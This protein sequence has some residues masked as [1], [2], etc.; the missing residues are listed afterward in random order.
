V[1]PDDPI[2]RLFALEQFGI[3]LGLDN[4]RCL[5]TALGNPQHRFDTVHVGGTNGKGSVTAMVECAV[6]HAGYRT[7]RY[8][9]PHLAHI[10]ERIAVDGVA[11]QPERFREVTADVLAVV[12]RLRALGTLETTPTF[13][14]VTTAIAFEAFRRAGVEVGVIEVGLGGRFDATNVISPRV[15]AITSI[16]L[17]HQKH[18]GDSLASI[19]FEKAGILK[20]DVPAVIGD[21]Q[22]EAWNVI[23]KVAQEKGVELVTADS[24][25]VQSAVLRDGRA[26]IA[27]VT[28]RARYGEVQLGLSGRHQIANAVVAIRILELL[29]SGDWQVNA[30]DIVAGL[31][32]VTWPARLEWLRLAQGGQLLLDAAHNVAGAQALAEYLSDSGVAPL[33]MVLAVMKDKDVAGIVSALAA[34]ASRFVVTSV[35]KPRALSARALAESVRR[36]APAT[37][38]EVVEEPDRAV[39]VALADA[40]TA[41]AA[42]SIFFVGPLRDRLLAAGALSLQGS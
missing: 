17:D 9:S 19:A 35:P 33:P 21:V 30:D 37:S 15:V 18:L 3:K 32:D 29:G 31:R 22:A 42:G 25:L 6:R 39:S 10:E 8:T 38:V 26:T 41:A 34:V 20:S 24:K 28:P 23:A 14:E 16:A 40:P 36:I 2:E 11:I 5:V 1:T 27:V 13:F 7:G 4:I 12:D